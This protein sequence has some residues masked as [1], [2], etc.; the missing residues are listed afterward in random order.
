MVL[1]GNDPSLTSI[2]FARPHTVVVEVQPFGYSSGPYRNFARS[3]NLTYNSV[4][5]QPDMISFEKCVQ[6]RHQKDWPLGVSEDEMEARMNGLLRLFREASEN[7]D[8][9]TASLDLTTTKLSDGTVRGGYIPRERVCARAQRLKVDAESV[10][11][12]IAKEAIKICQ[13]R[14]EQE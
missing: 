6:E 12:I 11:T 7:F 14:K 13:L 3:L 5:A 8:G 2:M 9:S 10:A 1:S 4:M